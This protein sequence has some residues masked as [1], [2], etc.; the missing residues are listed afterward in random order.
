VG[1][2]HEHLFLVVQGQVEAARSGPDVRRIHGTGDLVCGLPRFRIAC[3][4]GMRGPGSRP[5][6]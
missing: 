6:S 5:A 4:R 2:V 3:E 1:E